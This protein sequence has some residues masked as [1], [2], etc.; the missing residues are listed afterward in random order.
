M[1]HVYIQRFDGIDE[2]I[3]DEKLNRALAEILLNR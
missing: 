3:L 2:K 1:F